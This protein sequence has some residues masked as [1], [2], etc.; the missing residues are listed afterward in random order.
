MKI[1]KYT[2]NNQEDFN[3]LS[4]DKRDEIDRFINSIITRHD[5][6]TG[7]DNINY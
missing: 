4:D 6:E 1:K 5:F 2:K 7:E 3:E